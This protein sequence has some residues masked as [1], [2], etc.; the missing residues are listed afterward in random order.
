LTEDFRSLKLLSDIQESIRTIE[1]LTQADGFSFGDADRVPRLAIERSFEIIGITL[2]RLERHRPKIVAGI[3]KY[4]VILAFRNRI[5]HGYFDDLD[6]EIFDEVIRDHLP[7]L[8]QEVTE[9]L[10]DLG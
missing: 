7:I 1:S 4:P 10:A 9:R 8:H 2:T 5:A 3:A 6:S